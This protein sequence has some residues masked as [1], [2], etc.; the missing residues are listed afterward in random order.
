MLLQTLENLKRAKKI[1]KCFLNY[2]RSVFILKWEGWVGS[3]GSNVK[4]W[5]ES[6]FLTQT[7]NIGSHSAAKTK[8]RLI[9]K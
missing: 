8:R 4:Y 7:E 9:T 6:D 1:V 2:T 3:R 5:K